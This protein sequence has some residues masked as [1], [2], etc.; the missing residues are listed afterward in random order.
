M[1]TLQTGIRDKPHQP[2]PF[3]S[4]YPGLAELHGR[5][6][7]S[8]FYE[9]TQ[10]ARARAAS[11]ATL[12]PLDYKFHF[13]PWWQEE[14]YALEDRAVVIGAEDE[15]YFERRYAAGV[16]GHAGRGVRA[17]AGGRLL[18]AGPLCGR[19]AGPHRRFPYDPKATVQTFWDLGRNDLNTIW[20]HQHVN[21]FDRFIG[22]HENSGEFIG[23]Y[24]A[25]LNAWARERNASFEDHYIPHNGD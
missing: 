20:L 3:P 24:V 10:R 17:G 9:M 25:W 13:F 8:A 16:S 6:T 11:G 7:P 12:T 19:Q 1:R 14:A 5:S 18:C 21:G 22:Y 23:H 15:R 2:T 4:S